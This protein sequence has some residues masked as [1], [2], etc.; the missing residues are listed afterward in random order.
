MRSPGTTRLPKRLNERE[1]QIARQVLKEIRARLGFLVDVG[2]DYLTLDRASG[3]L[4]GGEAQR[5]RLATQIG[6]QPDGRALHPRRAV[7]RPPPARQRPAHRDARPAARPRQHAARRRARRGDDPLGRLGDRHRS[8]GGRARRPAD[9]LRAAGR[10]AR[11]P[12]VDHRGLPARRQGG[13]GAEAAAEREGRGDRR[14]RGAREQPEGA[15]TSRS[16]SAASWR[17]PG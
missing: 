2:L 15:S 12:S 7:D 16:R 4:S 17:S 10:A 5:I 3:T 11:E 6:S 1:N 9:P 8:G 13:A 14:A